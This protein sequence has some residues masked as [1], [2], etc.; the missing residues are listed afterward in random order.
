MG[1]PEAAVQLV[2]VRQ[3]STEESTIG[4]TCRITRSRPPRALIQIGAIVPC[5]SIQRKE[6]HRQRIRASAGVA[7]SSNMHALCSCRATAMLAPACGDAELRS[8]EANLLVAKYNGT[9]QMRR[10]GIQNSLLS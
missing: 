5:L 8:A 6:K 9:A 7:T 4:V 1:F 10:I 2:V 3:K